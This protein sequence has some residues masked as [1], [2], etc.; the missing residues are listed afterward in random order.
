METVNELMN[1]MT[2]H[3]PNIIRDL[4][5]MLIPCNLPIILSARHLLGFRFSCVQQVSTFV[6][7]EFDGC[8]GN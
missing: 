3:D 6:S 7:V 5:Y 4:A 1:L 8:R 2:T